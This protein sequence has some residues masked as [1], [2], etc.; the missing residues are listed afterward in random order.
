MLVSEWTDKIFN[1]TD[2]TFEQEA[3]EIFHYQYLN[4]PVYH[5]FVN[6]TGK[7]PVEVT[8][9]NQIPFLPISLFKTRKI[10]TGADDHEMVFRSS[11]TGGERSSHFV[12]DLSL[13]EKI[14]LRAFE[15]NYGHPRQYCIVGLLPSYL[16]RQNSSL[17][18]MV[19]RLIRLSGNQ[20]SG[21]YLDNL[22]Q[23]QK[24]LSELENEGQASLLIGV[25][26]ALLDFVEKCPVKLSQCVV[27]E[28]GGMKGRR[29]EMTRMELH[30]RLG[31][32]FGLE[33][34]HSEYGMTELLSQA[35]S[36]GKGI[37]IAPSWMR[38]LLREEEDPFT[39]SYSGRGILNIID[40]GNIHSCCFI[41]TDD[42]GEVHADGSFEVLGR[43][44]GADLRGCSLLIN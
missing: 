27:M 25:S 23:L 41:A 8:R 24:K 32:G 44:D 13:Y 15:E 35:Y 29:E 22:K 42:A 33:N 38:V 2:A 36:K 30:Q 12:K 17:V 43:R 6:A 19:D 28:T 31:D 7:R 40:L 9:I 5:D 4:N 26:F 39:V 10:I 18:Y 3:L 20:N 34:I 11:G 14:F 21:F 37:F 1:V 16:E